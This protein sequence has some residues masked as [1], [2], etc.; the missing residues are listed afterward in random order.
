MQYLHQKNINGYIP[1]N[2][3]RSR[4]PKFANQKEKYPRASRAKSKYTSIIAAKEFDFDP[5]TLNCQCP[6]GKTLSPRGV[7]KD[8]Q[9]RNNALFMGL[10]SHCR[11]CDLKHKCMK[12]PEAVN[13]V[14]GIG[15]QVS[16]AINKDKN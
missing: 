3:F 11:G 16:F 4:D 5:V 9:G 12:N 14:N 2:K 8:Q 6:A 10:V 13:K 7:R 15:R 1:D